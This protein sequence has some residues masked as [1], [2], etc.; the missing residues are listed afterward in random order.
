MSIILFTMSA[1]IKNDFFKSL[2][3]VLAWGLETG[4]EYQETTIYFM[5]DKK[6]N[7]MAL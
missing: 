1:S 2:F 5:L 4:V 6:E 7:M 3:S